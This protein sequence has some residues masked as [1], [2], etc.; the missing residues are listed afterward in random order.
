MRVEAR[1]ITTWSQL[2]CTIAGS[3]LSYRYL[4]RLFCFGLIIAMSSAQ[5]DADRVCELLRS[6]RQVDAVHPVL[7]EMLRKPEYERM[8][9]NI[10]S[11]DLNVIRQ[12]SQDL[13]DSEITITQK[14]LGILVE[15][16]YYANAAMQLYV[17]EI[18]GLG[19]VSERQK[20]QKFIAIIQTRE[21]IMHRSS[22]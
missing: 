3:Q 14:A 13:A 12:R 18:L 21:H 8:F 20:S 1:S 16:K 6:Y 7:R 10:L 4:I 15:D 22:N 17:D 19:I 2:K 5:T 9:W 11:H